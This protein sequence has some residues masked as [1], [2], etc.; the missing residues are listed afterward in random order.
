MKQREKK[1]F[2]CKNCGTNYTS[3]SMNSQFCTIDCRKE[4]KVKDGKEPD[5]DYVICKICSRATSNV[6]GV[7]LRNHPGW[8]AERYKKEF[9]GIPVIA[10]NVLE[11]ITEGSKKAGALMSE[12]HHRERQSKMMLGEKN[13]MHKSNTTD[14]ERRSVSPFSPD[15]YL[16]KFPNITQEEAEAMAKDKLSEN[17][18]ISWV[19]KE[20]WMNKGYTEEEAIKIISKKQATF[21]LEK[22]IEKYGKQEGIKKW[23]ERQKKWKYKVFNDTTHISRGYSKISEEFI[24]SLLDVLN[25]M[26]YPNS[27]IL[28]GKNEKFIRTKE[29]NV[30][31]Y[32]L[33]FSNLKKIIEFNGDFWHANPNLFESN[34]L[35]K[36]KNM[37]AKEIWEYDAEK[38]KTAESHGYTV[39]TLWE[40][41]YR[42]DKTMAIKKCLDYLLI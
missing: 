18:I 8:T 37:T 25:K 12:P 21:S 9:P 36:P 30:Y 35:N 4:F 2:L 17:A 38:K 41:D 7:H 26:G 1:E 23:E 20:Y 34:Y 32:D 3:S 14:E 40:G 31:K 5:K 6:T 39:F 11:R 22:C 28:H 10:S 19:K 24:G 27:D 42:Q 15:F 16:K 13:P 33:V 29:G